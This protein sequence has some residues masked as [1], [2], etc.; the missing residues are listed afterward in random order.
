MTLLSFKLWGIWL[1]SIA[2]LLQTS[3]AAAIGLL[4]AFDAA[5]QNDP[6]YRAAKHENEAGQQFKVMG[7]SNLLPNVSASF[8]TSQNWQDF[9]Q[10]G[11]SIYQEYV[12]QTQT[13]QLRQPLFNLDSF[14]R[15]K[16]GIAQTNQ[17]DAQFSIRTQEMILRIVGA[18]AD[19]KHAEDELAL[20]VVQL[21]VYAE[22][23]QMNNRMFKKGEGTKTDMLETQSKFDLANAQVIEARYHLADM[24]NVLSSI[25]GLEVKELDSLSDDFHV[26][27]M[28]PAGFDEWKTFALERNPEIVAQRYTV[29]IARVETN[30]Q[31]AGHAPRID[32]VASVNRNK[33]DNP[34]FVG[35][36]ILT[37]S[38]GVQMNVPL[39]SGG[40]VSALTSQASANHEKA[41]AEL[42]VK[43]NQILVELRKQYNLTLSSALRI[44]ALT[45]SISSA[46]FLVEAMQ[47]S[48]KRGLRTNLD[49]L[50]AQQQL[51]TAKRDLAKAR[52]DYLSSYLALRK[53]AG[54][55]SFGDLQDI[56]SYFVA[57]Q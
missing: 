16:Q 1:L 23:Q 26:K 35:T 17:S 12:S 38:V 14:A 54:T 56:A 29:E 25:S 39:Y 34:F 49:T 7:R 44:N 50:N 53:A 4:Q 2:V 47:K 18:Y 28:Q 55:V 24:R 27:P 33:S 37:R 11:Q 46:N 42:D 52:Y 13:V 6:A 9:S 5:L 32:F 20:A 41:K 21:N 30:R 31:R 51:F 57:S 45:N 15:Y 19:A 36:D 48:A 40:N 8:S 10:R 3:N 43:I 22:Q